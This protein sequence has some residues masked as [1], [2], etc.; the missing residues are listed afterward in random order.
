DTPAGVPSGIGDPTWEIAHLFPSQGDWSE[1]EFLALPEPHRFELSDGRLE[2]LPMPT[3]FHALIG[4]YLLKRLW[5]Y[6]EANDV[7]LAVP[8]P[9]YVRLWP[10]EIRQPDVVFCFHESIGYR[11]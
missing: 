1:S 11:N 9:L 8:A 6:L 10:K 5:A 7:G 2:V 3:W 4:A